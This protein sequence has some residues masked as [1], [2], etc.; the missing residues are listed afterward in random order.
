VSTSLRVA[1]YAW[2]VGGAAW[3]VKL[4]LILAADGG[5]NV[6]IGA[7]FLVGIAALFVGGGAAS[8]ALLRRWSVWLAVPGALAGVAVTFTAINMLDSVLQSVVPASG[9]FDEEVGILGAAILALL[10]GLA[11]L[12]RRRW[13]R[14]A[15]AEFSAAS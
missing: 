12:R 13:P 6:A 5:D 10:L 15:S 7:A 14:P 2:L 4:L 3:L 9:W 1:A 8:Y 11:L